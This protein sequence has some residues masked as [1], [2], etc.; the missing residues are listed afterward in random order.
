MA[1]AAQRGLGA[2]VRGGLVIRPGGQ[3]RAGGQGRQSGQGGQDRQGRQE[4]VEW[5]GGG[6]PIP[7]E[8]SVRAGQRALAIVQAAQPDERLL[9]LLS[10]GA[11]ALMALP[12]EGVTLDDKQ[13]TTE[14]LLRAGANIHELNTVRKHLSAIKGGQLAA[15]SSTDWR[16][17]VVSDVVDDDLSVVASGPTVADASTFQ[18]ALDVLRRHGDG[19]VDCYPARSVARLMRGARGELADTPKPNDPRLALGE[20]LV[21]ASRRDAMRGAAT[22]AAARGY[23]VLRMD[24]AVVGEARVA[25]HAHLDAVTARIAR[26]DSPPDPICVVSSGETTVHVTGNG[27]GGRNQEFALALVERMPLLGACAALASLGTDGIDGPTDAA[28]AIVDSRSAVRAR[29]SGLSSNSFLAANNAYAFFLAMGDLVHT[30]PTGT[31]VGDLQII[32]L[33]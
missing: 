30:G 20:A 1:A 9:F 4:P 27:R 11:S 26:G 18:D 8:D 3:R 2:S 6:H 13:G 17:L 32:L 12:A 5:M 7:T 23:H 28:G 16:T 15:A 29:Q 14:C 31:N 21:I 33:A 25:A 22:A 24:E 19:T 10:G